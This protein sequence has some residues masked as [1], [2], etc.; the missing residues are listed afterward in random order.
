[1]TIAALT[2]AV[3]VGG[4]WLL[5]YVERRAR[6]R[7]AVMNTKLRQDNKELHQ[8]AEILRRQRDV[9]NLSADDLKRLYKSQRDDSK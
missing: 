1:M 8:N 9:A 3:C 7:T 6:L 5:Y 2:I 4:V